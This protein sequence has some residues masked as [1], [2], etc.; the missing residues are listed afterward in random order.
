MTTAVPVSLRWADIRTM[1]AAPRRDQLIATYRAR[2]QARREAA[3]AARAE[4]PRI[5]H[6]AELHRQLALITHCD[7][8]A[9]QAG[10]RLILERRTPRS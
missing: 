6:D 7:T 5:R 8:E 3:A 4:A 2:V 1:P 10:R 9:E